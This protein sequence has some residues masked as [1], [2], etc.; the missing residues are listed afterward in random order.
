MV[1][2]P[3]NPNI[4]FATG[5]SSPALFGLFSQRK[6]AVQGISTD[7]TSSTV[8]V[9]YVNVCVSFSHDGLDSKWR[10]AVSLHIISAVFAAILLLA[11]LAS[12]GSDFSKTTYLGIGVVFVVIC[13]LFQALALLVFRSNFCTDNPVLNREYIIPVF[14]NYCELGNGGIMVIVAA[15]M[16]LLAGLASCAASAGKDE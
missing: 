12:M 5:G 1:K 8:T 13:C 6:L 10:A 11:L 4:S 16:Y 3:V 7:S 15:V 14:A 2:I 9:S